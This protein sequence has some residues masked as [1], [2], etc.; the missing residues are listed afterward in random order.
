MVANFCYL[1]QIFEKNEI[2]SIYLD[3]TISC[4]YWKKSLP[5]LDA[6]QLASA[7]SVRESLSIF[8]SA[9]NILNESAQ[10]ENLTKP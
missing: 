8:L 10:F 4:F 5:T 1:L 3:G 7:F 9:D 2:N 6:I